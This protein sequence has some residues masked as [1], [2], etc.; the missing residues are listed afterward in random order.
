LS[1]L[2]I[3]GAA[4]LFSSGSTLKAASSAV[5]K[6]GSTF[7]SLLRGAVEKP[8][9]KS[10][11]ETKPANAPPKHDSVHGIDA[12][13]LSAQNCANIEAFT[14]QFRAL[15]KESGIEP[16][17]NID[18]Q[19]DRMGQVRVLGNPFDKAKIEGILAS[20][21]ELANQFRQ[22]SANAGLLRAIEEATAQQNGGDPHSLVTDSPQLFAPNEASRFTLRVSADRAQPLFSNE[23]VD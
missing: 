3:E 14:A 10:G 6:A 19:V 17:G 9:E 16:G 2:P 1:I 22:I 12:A 5:S 11:E 20:H 23:T 18:L 8:D 7:A 15:L 21:P 13:D 4:S